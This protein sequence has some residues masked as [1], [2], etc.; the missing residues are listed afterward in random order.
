MKLWRSMSFFSVS[1]SKTP[2]FFRVKLD[3]LKMKSF[4]Y[5]ELKTLKMQLERHEGQQQICANIHIFSSGDFFGVGSFAKLGN[6]VSWSVATLGQTKKL[7]KQLSKEEMGLGIDG[8]KHLQIR[9]M[10]FW[11][12]Y[13]DVYIAPDGAGFELVCELPCLCNWKLKQFSPSSIIWQ[14][15]RRKVKGDT[16]PLQNRYC[17]TPPKDCMK[18]SKSQDIPANWSK[19]LAIFVY[20][21]QP[22]SFGRARRLY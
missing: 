13:L 22:C 21:C 7:L 17:F 2:K 15:K 3:V 10:L 20:R 19:I 11:I 4:E 18:P 9:R 1:Q 16:R 14:V 5:Q 8:M 12:L 6:I